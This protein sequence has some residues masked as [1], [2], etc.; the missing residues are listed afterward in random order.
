MTVVKRHAVQ[1]CKIELI[2]AGQ[3][4]MHS[5]GKTRSH[6]YVNLL[7]GAKSVG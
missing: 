6:G 3:H 4:F 2:G 1:Q 5:R 7:A